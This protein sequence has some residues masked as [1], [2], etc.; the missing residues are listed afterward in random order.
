MDLVSD[1]RLYY[2]SQKKIKII[3]TLDSNLI[4]VKTEVKEFHEM[5]KPFG[6]DYIIY[7]YIYVIIG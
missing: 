6:K 4:S 2:T 7:R 3:S 5:F 1:I